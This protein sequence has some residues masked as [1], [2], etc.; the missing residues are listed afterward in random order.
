MI[1]KIIAIGDQHFKVDNIPEI[2]LFIE[3][4]IDIVNEKQPDLVVLLGD[5]LDT[6]DR[7]NIYALNKAC[8]FI[9]RLRKISK[10][11]V[12]VG[13]H[14]MGALSFLTQNHWLNPLKEW[15]NAVIVDKPVIEEIN[16]EKFIFVPFVPN[17]MFEKALSILDDNW[18]DAS[19]IFCHQEF[20]GCSMGSIISVEGDKWILE[21][22]QIISGHIHNKQKPQENIFYIG[23]STQ[24]SFGDDENKVVAYIEFENKKHIVEEIELSLPK[25]KILHMDIDEVNDF[26]YEETNDKIKVSVSG[27]YEEFKTFK[28]TK[29]YK[30]MINKGIKVVFKPKRIETKLKNQSIQDNIN[31]NKDSNNFKEIL[32]TMIEKQGNP[33]LTE[34]Y[35]LVINNREV[36]I[37]KF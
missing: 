18:K 7:I 3:K 31:L 8:E 26:N 29:K 22:P 10:T 1:T 32:E 15:E 27:V 4:I 17:G 21:Y 11:I 19:I 14:D 20:Y 24:T 37:L 35:E 33:W 25:K 2:E 13:N 30:E 12:I 23:S 34:V 36:L 28:K 5:M 16:G 6:F 9:N